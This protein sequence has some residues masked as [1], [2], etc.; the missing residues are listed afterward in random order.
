MNLSAND[1]KRGEE[2]PPIN[3]DRNAKILDILLHDYDATRAEI[4]A[5][6]TRHEKVSLWLSSGLLAATAA[7][8]KD[9]EIGF[10]FIPM[11]ILA[12]YAHRL[13]SH[14]L[15]VATLSRWIMRI[16]DLV[17]KML[18][19][20]GLLDWERNFVRQKLKSF[21][22]TSIFSPHY[23]AEGFLLLPSILVFFISVFFS[24][25]PAAQAFNM[26]LSLAKY[27]IWIGYPV[28]FIFLWTLFFALSGTKGLDSARKSSVEKTYR[29]IVG[30]Q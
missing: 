6:E 8:F 5:A 27:L 26:P 21:S 15:H 13:Y 30:D 7:C 28:L 11:V 3:I 14:T 2:P 9:F 10:A 17:D 4:R 22:I 16:E 1:G 23:I 18:N 25:G 20:Q 19:T 12:Y 29:S 24:P